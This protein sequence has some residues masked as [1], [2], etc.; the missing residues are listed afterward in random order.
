MVSVFDPHQ[1]LRSLEQVL[2]V[3]NHIREERL[4]LRGTAVRAARALLR[5]TASR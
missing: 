3:A 2:W 1:T 4:R 5:A